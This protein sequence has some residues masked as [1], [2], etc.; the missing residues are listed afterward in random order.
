MNLIVSADANGANAKKWHVMEV[1]QGHGTLD[2]TRLAPGAQLSVMKKKST[3]VLSGKMQLNLNNNT[4]GKA[5]QIRQVELQNLQPGDVIDV[6]ARIKALFGNYDCT[7]LVTG[8][9]I[10][11]ADPNA[12]KPATHDDFITIKNGRNCNDHT[13][14]GCKYVE[15]GA[16]QVTTGG[17]LYVSHIARAGRTP[18]PPRTRRGR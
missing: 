9:V 3:Q 16:V 7:P 11:S 6:D 1:E 8:Q 14:K 12:L 17:T 2:V 10:V 15:S 18:C 13:S 4:G 5:Y